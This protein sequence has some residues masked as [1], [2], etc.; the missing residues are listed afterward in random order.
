MKKIFNGPHFALVIALFLIM[1]LVA[2]VVVTARAQQGRPYKVSE[3]QVRTLLHRLEERADAFRS[4]VD[5]VLEVSR[6]DG[7]QREDRLDRLVED[8]ERASDDLQQRFDKH[9]ATTADVERVL[10]AAE[11]VDSPLTRA[12]ADQTLHPDPSLRERAHIEWE[13]IKSSLNNLADFYNIVSDGEPGDTALCNPQPS[14]ST[15]R[16]KIVGPRT[17]TVIV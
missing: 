13:L 12:L 5:I 3:E 16:S 7:T 4:I 14:A 15:L 9:A 1:L 11:R 10:R 17:R 8:F 6:L 2:C